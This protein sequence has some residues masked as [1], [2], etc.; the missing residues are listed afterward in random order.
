MTSPTSCSL[1]RPTGIRFEPPDCLHSP[2]YPLRGPY[3]SHSRDL[4]RQHLQEMEEY[5][6]GV[7]VSPV[8]GRKGAGQGA[9]SRA[10]PAKHNGGAC[11]AETVPV[12]GLLTWCALW[13]VSE[14]ML[15][16]SYRPGHGLP[17]R[18]VVSWWGPPWREGSHDTQKVNTDQRV[19]QVGRHGPHGD[20]GGGTWMLQGRV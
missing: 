7:M 2:F 4:I 5:G 10:Q 13:T 1:V 16:L 9:A 19:E 8:C 20:T 6:I 12:P 18:Q 14:T 17:W 11:Q 3:S 15:D